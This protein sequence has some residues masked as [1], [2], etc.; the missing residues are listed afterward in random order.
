MLNEDEST[1]P[2]SPFGAQRAIARE[3][4][5]VNREIDALSKELLKRLLLLR[6]MI[7]F[8]MLMIGSLMW[9]LV[10]YVANLASH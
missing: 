6:L 7:A 5:A 10:T 3:L 2:I 8:L 1:P 4:A 9:F